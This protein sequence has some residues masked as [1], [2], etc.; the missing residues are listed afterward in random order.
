M[1]G[2]REIDDLKPIDRTIFGMVCES[3]GRNA[4]ERTGSLESGTLRRPSPS[5]PGEGSMGRRSLA[6]AA[7]HSGGV[8]AGSTVTRTPIRLQELRRRR[9]L[10]G[11]LRPRLQGGD[12]PRS[13]RAGQGE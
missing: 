8:V 6:D 7:D 12:A 13:L 9:A 4:S 3:P 2:R 11:P 5:T 1:A 10:L